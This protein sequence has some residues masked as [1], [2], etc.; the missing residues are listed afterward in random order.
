MGLLFV[1][2]SATVTT[3]LVVYKA[4]SC[5]CCSAWVTHMEKNGF[6]VKVEEVSDV[7]AMKRQLGVPPNIDSCHTGV[8]G[9]YLVEGHVPAGDVLRLLEEK[10]PV[11]GIAVPGMP[12]GSPGMEI[13]GQKPDAYQVIT[14]TTEGQ[15]WLFAKH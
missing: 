15:S 14:F 10:P 13:S 1:P 4:A 8:I 6:I 5:G 9:D 12:T 11:R 3:N 2:S 7:T